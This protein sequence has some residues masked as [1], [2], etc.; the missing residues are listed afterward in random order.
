FNQLKMEEF[1]E[2]LTMQL[3]YPLFLLQKLEEKLARSS[4]G[5]IVFIGSVYGGYGS[6]MEVGYS[7]I[8]GALSVFVKDYSEVVASLGTT[9]NFVS[10]GAVDSRMNYMFSSDVKEQVAEDIPM[11]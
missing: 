11:W 10:Q 2:M 7:T 4:L 9:V 1:D 8:K 3:R 6:A 5:R